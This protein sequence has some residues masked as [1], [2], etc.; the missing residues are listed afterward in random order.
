MMEKRKGPLIIETSLGTSTVTELVVTST[1][2]STAPVTSGPFESPV[3]QTITLTLV[4]TVFVVETF[5]TNN[6]FLLVKKLPP[7]FVRSFLTFNSLRFLHFQFIPSPLEEYKP[8][9]LL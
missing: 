4:E 9:F 6:C 8:K 3:K 7:P 1:T 2:W 5:E